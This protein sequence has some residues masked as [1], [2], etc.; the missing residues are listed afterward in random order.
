MA[1]GLGLRAQD[2]VVALYRGGDFVSALLSDTP[3]PSGTAITLELYGG[4]GSI[5]W[6]ATVSGARADWDIHVAGVAAVL[7]AGHRYARLNYS[8]SA[9]DQVIWAQGRIDAH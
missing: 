2:L 3:W 9:G 8:T 7:D 5:V 4:T 1:I 6:P